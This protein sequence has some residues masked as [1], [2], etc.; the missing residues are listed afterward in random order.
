VPRP[1]LHT[2]MANERALGIS[3]I[4]AAQT[5]RQLA[6]IFGEHQAR[7]LFGLTNVLVL[8]G[9]S[10]LPVTGPFGPGR[11]SMVLI[12]PFPQSGR[13][14]QLAYRELDLAT[15]RQQDHLLPLRDLAN[16]PRPWDLGT[17]ETPQLRKEVW[18]WLEAIVTWLNQEY[19]WDVADVIP[20]C[21]PQHRHVVHEIAVLADQRHR[22]GQALTGEALEEWH[23]YSLPSFT[24]RMWT[25]LLNHCQEDHQSWPAKG[26]YTRHIAEASCR[27]RV[28]ACDGDVRAL[29][30]APDQTQ[31]PRLGLVDLDR[32]EIKEL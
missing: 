3:F 4:Y 21:W 1:T 7:A 28:D 19:V 15:S 16:V 17:C 11:D 18:S 32:G 31:L 22:A 5:W 10:L 8:F 13:L 29:K 30:S 14:V 20:P 9:G 24:E 2:R 23:R 12:Q 6:A 27:R 25:R 26:R